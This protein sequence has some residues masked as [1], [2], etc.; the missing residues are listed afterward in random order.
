MRVFES[1]ISATPSGH[2]GIIGLIFL[3]SRDLC[4]VLNCKKLLIRVLFLFNFYPVL[5]ASLRIK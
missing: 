5:T 4:P 1:F 3:L 2:R